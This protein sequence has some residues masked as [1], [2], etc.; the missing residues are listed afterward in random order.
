MKV[1]RFE[2]GQAL[3][4]IAL[5]IIGLAAMAGLVIDGGKAFADR[6]QAQNAADSA[7]L[8]AAY[9][10]IN[11]G[12][13]LV[14]AALES[15]SRNGYD[16]NGITNTVQV[17]SPPASGPHENDL[18]YIQVIIVSHV[19]TYIS[20]IVGRDE[21]INT[22]TATA[23]TKTPE[24][25]KLLNG[26]AVVSL[27]PNSDCNNDKSFWV[28]G[29]ATLSIRGGGIWINSGNDTC[30]LIEQGSGSLRLQ[31]GYN[32]DIVGGASIQKAHLLTP[33]VTVGAVPINYPPPFMMPKIGCAQLAEVSPDGTTMS[34]GAW[35]DI[36][37]P[38]GVTYL[39][40][41]IYCLDNGINITNDIEGHNVVFKVVDGEV[42]FSSEADILLDAPNHGKH[43]G[44][45]I[46]LPMDNP[47]KVVLNGG[48]ESVIKGTILA[49]AS[50]VLIKG[51]SSPFGFHSQIIGYTIEA[52]GS[53][54]VEI[55]YNEEQNYHALNMPEVQL[56]E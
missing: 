36:F 31:E 26:A 46:Y 18:E 40:S 20:S 44:L 51:L 1:Y 32:I 21:I 19:K 29:E 55:I 14:S 33:A 52:D 17:H 13:D 38:P 41:G 8:D 42:R 12:T 48:S 9:M 50:H 49:P 56:S 28:H 6:R 54:N 5:A 30:A 25:T 37:P 7:A 39:Q 24:V 3:I 23:R 34:A 16:N 15:A 43:A 27:A 35:S 2:R 11:G 22:V 47:H 53:D 10:R 4:I 45:L